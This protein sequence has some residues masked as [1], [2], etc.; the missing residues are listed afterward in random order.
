MAE[1]REGFGLTGTGVQADGQPAIRTVF[2]TPHYRV[3]VVKL[4]NGPADQAEELRIRYVI[5]SKED[6]VI[7]AHSGLKGEAVALAL[8]AEESYQRAIQMA[9]EA[10]ARSFKPDE[11][12][13]PFGGIITGGGAPNLG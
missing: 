8:A 6:P 10:Q 12:R 11:S 2:Q 5:L 3:V 7:A 13:Q 4:T 1:K 9:T